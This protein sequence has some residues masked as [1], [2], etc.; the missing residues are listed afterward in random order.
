MAE[1]T[2]TAT[3]G[4][5]SAEGQRPEG[6]RPEGQRSDGPRGADPGA[7]R[8]GG[9]DRLFFLVL[10]DPADLDGN[11][12]VIGHL[13]PLRGLGALDHDLPVAKRDDAIGEVLEISHDVL[14][15]PILAARFRVRRDGSA[16]QT[17]L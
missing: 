16:A 15:R 12:A 3:P 1:E 17:L 8:V 13:E 4:A 2:K 9:E 14:Q 10:A 6:Q 5:P 11:V 7:A